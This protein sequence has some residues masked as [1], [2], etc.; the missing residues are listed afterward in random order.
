VNTVPTISGTTPGSRCGT[1]TVSL[2][3]TASAGTINWYAAATGGASLFAG[4]P[5]TTPSISATTTY[6][7]DATANGCISA[8]RTPVI[9][10]VNTVPTISGTT[11]GSRCGTGTVSLAA[12]ASAGTIN[13]Y[14][15]ATGGASLFAGS[16]FTT[17]SISVSTT[18]YTD[19][20]LNSCTTLARTAVIATVNPLPVPGITGLISVC[21]TTAGVQ[22][23][24]DPG[25]TSYTWTISSGGTITSGPTNQTVTVTWNTSGTQWVKVNYINANN[26]SAS[27]ATQY[28]VTVNPLSASAGII[29]GETTVYQGQVDVIYSVSPITNA[30]SYIWELPNGV[31]GS[32]TSNIIYLSFTNTSVSGNIIVKGHNNCGDGVQSQ[33]FVNILKHIQLKLYLEGLFNENNQ[34]MK[35]AQDEYGD[36]FQMDISDQITVELHHQT[37]PYSIAYTAMYL[38]LKTNGMCELAVP[39][40]LQDT[41]YI[42]IKHRNHMETW[43]KVPVSFAGETVN[44]DF[45]TS[46]MKAFGDNLKQLATGKYGFFAGDMNG[47]GKIDEND[48]TQIKNSSSIFSFGY[49][50]TDVNG[51]GVVDALDLIITDNNAAKFISVMKP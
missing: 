8:S 40:E 25:M 11:P 33:L 41:Y 42:V 6:Y 39:A 2:A 3:A 32:S 19:A 44:Y 31:T 5:F 14:V 38:N 17:P 29:T 37:F 10:T 15:A 16:P 34:L 47:D 20:T 26:C 50:T 18:Y 4:S 35:K 21:E 49:I 45:S 7:V 23:T 30:T 43:S 1:G 22:Y 12:T 13:W 51:D 36:H 46:E 9:A 24:T 27:T 48:I 28:N